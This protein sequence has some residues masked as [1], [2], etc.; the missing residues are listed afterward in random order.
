MSRL[1]DAGIKAR[2][3]IHVIVRSALLSVHQAFSDFLLCRLIEQT[4]K[5]D[6][7][8]LYRHPRQSEYGRG[9]LPSGRSIEI[10]SAEI[11]NVF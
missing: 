10:E 2:D 8:R 3:T 4:S 6:T 1:L 9:F 11:V 5:D 7:F